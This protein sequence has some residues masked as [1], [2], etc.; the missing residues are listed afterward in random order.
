MQPTVGQTFPDFTAPSTEGE[1][2]L[3]SLRGKTVV[4]YVYP[5]DNTP[6]CT[7]E[8]ENFRNRHADFAAAGAVVLGLSRDTLASHQ[9]FK[10]KYGFPFA[11]LADP[12]EVL[13]NA[14]GLLKEKNM[15]GKKVKGVERTTYLIDAQG[16]LRQVWAAVKVPGHV[17]EVLEA[18]RSL[19]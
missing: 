10:A 9:K 8:G 16:V 5:R 3:S 11:L 7:T 4:L 6:G 15:Y 12:E 1:I 19:A 17:E 2:R 13:V 14:W 18:V